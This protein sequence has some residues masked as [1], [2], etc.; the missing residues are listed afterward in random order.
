[1][2]SNLILVALLESFSSRSIVGWRFIFDCLLWR[3][4]LA[5]VFCEGN[6][7]RVIGDSSMLLVFKTLQMARLSVT[8]RS[9]S[10]LGDLGHVSFW[11][12]S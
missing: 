6:C 5:R 7:A 2:S 9:M 10:G 12:G 1:M 3:A 8:K 4:Y 11:K